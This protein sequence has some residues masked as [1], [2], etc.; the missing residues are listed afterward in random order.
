M[1][2][3]CFNLRKI[4]AKNLGHWWT[5]H[6]GTLTWKTALCEITTCMLWISK[7]NVGNDIYDTAVCLLWKALIFTTVTSFHVE[8]RN[9]ESFSTN[10]TEAWISVT[11]NEYCIR[12]SG[13]HEFVWG[14]DDIT[15]SSTKVITHS[16]H[17]HFRGCKFKILEEDAIKVIVIILTCVSKNDVKILTCL[18]NH[19]SQT[20][21]LWSCTNNDEKLEAT[22][23]L[24][25]YVWIVC[26]EFHILINFVCSINKS[27]IPK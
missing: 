11:Q 25:T 14:I 19:S 27:A 5:S 1:Y 6:I 23:I 17:I 20:N 2:A 8:D 22:I 13:G 16:I 9:M 3:G 26:S 10:D 24:E 21:N 7:V 4:L 15:T 12:L 18:I